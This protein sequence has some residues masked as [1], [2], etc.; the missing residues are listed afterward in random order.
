MSPPVLRLPSSAGGET[1][2]IYRSPDGSGGGGSS[3]ADD[4]PKPQPRS[5][6]PLTVPHVREM[7]PAQV[8]EFWENPNEILV[9]LGFVLN[10]DAALQ[11]V[12]VDTIVRQFIKGGTT[13]L[14][15]WE[16]SRTPTGA[17]INGTPVGLCQHSMVRGEIGGRGGE[18]VTR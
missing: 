14:V 11:S 2:R 7:S 3:S 17:V 6:K 10:L 18:Q 4:D 5:G 8:R 13:Y 15:T 1:L 16:G 12:N 9:D